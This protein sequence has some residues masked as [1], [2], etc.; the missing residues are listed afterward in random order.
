[1]VAGGSVPWSFGGEGVRGDGRVRGD[2]AAGESPAWEC[3]RGGG[4]GFG[5]EEEGFAG[6]E[7]GGGLS[8]FQ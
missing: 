3:E 1:V 7:G 8:V 5:S 2:G 6:G 4:E